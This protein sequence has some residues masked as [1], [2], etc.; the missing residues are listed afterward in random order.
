MVVDAWLQGHDRRPAEI[1][2]ERRNLLQS[3]DRTMIV[4]GGLPPGPKSHLPGALVYRFWRDPVRA[5]VDIAGEYGDVSRFKFGPYDQVLVNDPEL[6]QRVL[7]ADQRSF[8]KGRAL[9]EAKRVLG[10]GLLTS[11]GELHLRQRRLI[12]PIF[13]RKAIAAYGEAM[14]ESA[15]RITSRWQSGTA[16]DVHAEMARLTLTI[17]GRTLFGADLEG[18]AGLIG[19]A[20]TEALEGVNRVVYPGGALWERLPLPSTRRFNA[21]V[22]Q[23]DETIYGLIDQRRRDGGHGSD[24]LSMLLAAQDETGGGGMSDRQVRDEAMTLFIAGHETT[25]VL[26]TWTLYLLAENPLVES[27]LREEIE[28]VVGRGPVSADHLPQ[29]TYVDQV[30]HESLRLYPPAWVIGRR[31]LTDIKLGGYVVPAE[32]IV[33]LSPYVTQ[34]DGRWFPE[35]GRFDPERWIPELRSARPPFSFFPFGGGTRLCIGEGFAMMEAKIVLATIV[36]RWQLRRVS[37]RPPELLPRVT[38]RPKHGMRMTLV[39]T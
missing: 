23:L 24:L 20:L 35:P 6:V 15:E 1:R 26:L 37:D 13:H 11:E 3:A 31:A 18:E 8:M 2:R 28:S 32:T 12:Q 27:R 19:A 33:V 5:L 25:A 34:R 9:Q 22:H 39:R 7:V 38:L 21:A 16:L 10:E 4:E 36:R 30:L 14:V 29:L 17:V